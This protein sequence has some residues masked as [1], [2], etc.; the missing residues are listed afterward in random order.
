MSLSLKNNASLDSKLIE[1]LE[2]ATSKIVTG[3][4]DWL[5]LDKCSVGLFVPDGVVEKG[6]ELFSVE[7]TDEEWNRPILQDGEQKDLNILCNE[8]SHVPLKVA[9]V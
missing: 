4:G 3:D 8:V 7:I 9:G 6:E 2:T 5:Y 1:T